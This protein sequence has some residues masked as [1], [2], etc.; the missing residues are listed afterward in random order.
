[1][2]LLSYSK[3]GDYVD[4]ET[5]LMSAGQAKSVLK[6]I[7]SYFPKAKFKIAAKSL[8]G[9]LL[10]PESKE[11]LATGEEVNSEGF[12]LNEK[13][14]QTP[15]YL[16]PENLTKE[17]LGDDVNSA[18]DRMVEVAFHE[19][20]GHYG[21]RRMFNAGKFNPEKGEF[22]GSRYNKFIKKFELKNRRKINWTRNTAREYADASQFVKAEEYI[23]RNFA[24]KF[25]N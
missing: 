7:Q 15:V 5:P 11:I 24:E 3:R 4:G 16:V 25:Q 18:V 8:K 13:G 19:Y 2:G 23:A 14:D 12:V 22:S 1:M 10:D 6:T 17:Y 9:N 20:L 21:L